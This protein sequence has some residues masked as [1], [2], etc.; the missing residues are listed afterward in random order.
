MLHQYSTSGSLP[1]TILL[2][3]PLPTPVVR[4]IGVHCC[5]WLC[6]YLIQALSV[7]LCNIVVNL[8]LLALSWTQ[9]WGLPG[10]QSCSVPLV[11]LIIIL[12]S[13]Y[14]EL[15]CWVSFLNA[16]FFSGY[17][18]YLLRGKNTLWIV[19][20]LLSKRVG[21]HSPFRFSLLWRLLSPEITFW[22]IGIHN[23]TLWPLPCTWDFLWK[24]NNVMSKTTRNKCYRSLSTS[25]EERLLPF[26]PVSSLETGVL[27]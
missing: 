22:R 10:T 7:S 9:H 12:N 20:V 21:T 17:S 24:A 6:V 14:I 2:S 3:S 15:I 8:L 16:K 27:V 13:M 25:H 18:G 11:S 26:Y 4:A 5:A 1:Q 19:V 23:T